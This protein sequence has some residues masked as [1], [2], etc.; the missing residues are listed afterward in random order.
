M[1]IKKIVEGL[2]ID[3]GAIT[4]DAVVQIVNTAVESVDLTGYA[5]ETYVTGAVNDLIDAAPGALNTLNELAAALGDDAN[6]AT[7][8]STSIGN[9]QDKVSGV[10]DTEIGYLDGVTSAIQTQINGKANT[11]HTHAIS[12]VTNLQTS[13]GAKKNEVTYEISNN[14][15][16]TAGGR[17]M[18]DTGTALTLTLP[19][20]PAVGDEIQ[21]FDKTNTA[22]TNNITVNNNGLKINGVVDTLIIDVNGAVAVLVYTG[23]SL[24]WRI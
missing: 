7:T 4:E 8:V 3:K 13:L 22:E 12:D 21:I 6:L 9:K 18:V 20:T 16:L 2:S 15:N 17:Y 10:S 11:S 23:S 24:G 14:T 19:A 5:T 1:A